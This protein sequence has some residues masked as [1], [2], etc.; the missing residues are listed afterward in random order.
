[1]TPQLIRS[2][3]DI[4]AVPISKRTCK[5]QDDEGQGS[6]LFVQEELKACLFECLLNFASETCGCTPWNYPHE[7]NSSNNICDAEGNVCF[8]SQIKLE[9]AIKSCQ[10][11]GNCQ[12]TKYDYSINSERLEAKYCV[13][14]KNSWSSC[15]VKCT[16]YS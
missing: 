1:M 12:E 14:I 6:N 5:F 4:K 11:H 10:C 16:I 13:S 3:E 7:R 8:N 15:F 2:S 9:D